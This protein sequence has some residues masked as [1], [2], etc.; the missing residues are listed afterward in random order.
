MLHE[1]VDSD[2]LYTLCE[3]RYSM[4]CNYVLHFSAVSSNVSAVSSNVSAVSSNA[5]AISL[6][7]KN[8]RPF[9][10]GACVHVSRD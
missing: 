4:H 5:S 6:P 2:T 7:V 10:N 8:D 1:L 3:S 9:E